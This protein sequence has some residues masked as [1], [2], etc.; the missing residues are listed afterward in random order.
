[1]KTFKNYY[2]LFILLICVSAF[3]VAIASSNL[4]HDDPY[5]C[6][7]HN[8]QPIKNKYIACDHCS[9][10]FDVETN[11]NHQDIFIV[12]LSFTDNQNKLGFTYQTKLFHNSARSPPHS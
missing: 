11:Y 4:N 2:N 12:N 3:P 1:M 10:F 5:I 7:Y 9:Y 8:D 6:N